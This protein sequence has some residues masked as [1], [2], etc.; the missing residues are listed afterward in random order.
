MLRIASEMKEWYMDKAGAFLGDPGTLTGFWESPEVFFVCLARLCDERLKQE[1]NT[2]L[3]ARVRQ[4]EVEAETRMLALELLGFRDVAKESGAK[5]EGVFDQ[6]LHSMRRVTRVLTRRKDKQRDSAEAEGPSA[7]S[8]P[9]DEEGRER[10][11]RF[12]TQRNPAHERERPLG[13]DHVDE[14]A[15][16]FSEAADEPIDLAE[17]VAIPAPQLRRDPSQDRSKESASDFSEK[18]SE[19]AALSPAGQNNAFRPKPGPGGIGRMFF[20]TE[21]SHTAPIM[22]GSEGGDMDGG[23][24]DEEEDNVSNFEIASEV[25]VPKAPSSAGSVRPGGGD[26]VVGEDG[27]FSPPQ[28]PVEEMGVEEE[29]EDRM[30]GLAS[31]GEG[32][33]RGGASSPRESFPPRLGEGGEEEGE[34]G[35]EE[36]EGGGIDM[37]MVGCPETGA[38]RG[39]EVEGEGR[40]TE[41]DGSTQTREGRRRG[42]SGKLSSESPTIEKAQESF[43]SLQ[44][45]S[46]VNELLPSLLRVHRVREIKPG[47]SVSPQQRL[48]DGSASAQSA[49]TSSALHHL[50]IAR[51]IAPLAR[52]LFTYQGPENAFSASVRFLSS[53]TGAAAVS[54]DDL[55]DGLRIL[56]GLPK[57]TIFWVRRRAHIIEASQCSKIEGFGQEV[58]DVGVGGDLRLEDANPMLL[59]Q[60]SSGLQG[61]DASL[62][63]YFLNDGEEGTFG[64]R[65]GARQQQRQSVRYITANSD[66][67]VGVEGGDAVCKMQQGEYLCPCS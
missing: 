1:N 31:E 8:V 50:D 13:D 22:D 26:L 49:S 52:P 25:P 55:K 53:S 46:A 37:E 16:D 60:V 38:E 23:G 64:R 40:E 44:F 20:M 43:L 32:T 51:C 5:T 4:V 21:G 17:D 9:D 12:T 29:E 54:L 41:R 24:E 19:M 6:I 57:E 27:L 59:N 2:E 15:S 35:D 30:Y 62:V 63:L 18:D 56:E 14:N 36:G 7:G 45:S 11:L 28:G 3:R 33:A 10:G 65:G 58:R 61:N 34:G 48:S 39:E 42:E 47:A 66:M 67:D